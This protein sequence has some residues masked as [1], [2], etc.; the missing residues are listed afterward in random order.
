MVKQKG[1]AGLFWGCFAA[2][3]RL[4]EEHHGFL[5]ALG[6]LAL[7]AMPLLQRRKCDDH[8]TTGQ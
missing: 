2:A 6:Y 1:G 7:I 8:W 4:Y 5:E 3:G